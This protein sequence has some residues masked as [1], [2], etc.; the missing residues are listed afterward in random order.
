MTSTTDHERDLSSGLTSDRAKAAYHSAL[1]YLEDVAKTRQTD[2][3]AHEHDAPRPGPQLVADVM[4]DH[5]VSVRSAAT[6][7]EV[8]VTMLRNHVRAVPVIGD[9]KRVLGM[10]SE[11]DLL[12]RSAHLGAPLPLSPARARRRQTPVTALTAHELMT[13]PAVL[14]TPT[15]PIT[16]VSWLMAHRRVHQLPVVEADDTLVGIVSRVDLLRGYLRTDEEIRDDLIEKVIGHSF[17]LIARLM[18]VEVTDG[19]VTLSGPVDDEQLAADLRHAAEF[20][21]GVIDVNAHGLFW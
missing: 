17:G 6:F 15:M 21:P 13:A 20:V 7:R 1:H 8:V 16:S 5:V 3:Q 2:E 14:A 10:V 9:E 18:T 12:T 19:A 11:G 4:T